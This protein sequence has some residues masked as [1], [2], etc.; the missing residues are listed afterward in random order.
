MME[1][2]AAVAGGNA[3]APSQAERHHET[4][5]HQRQGKKK[6]GVGEERRGEV[7]KRKKK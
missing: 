1:I 3:S 5:A 4:R 6:E 7:R 2:H